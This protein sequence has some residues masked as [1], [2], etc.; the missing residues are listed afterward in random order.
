MSAI[1]GQPAPDFELPGSEGSMIKLSDYRG[2]KVILYFYPKDLTATCSTQACD[3]RDHHEQFTG[4][5]AIILGVSTDPLQRHSKFIEKYGLPFQLLADEEHTVSEA[6]GVWQQKQMYGKQYMGI[7]RSTF[8]I[9]EEGILV[10][11][12]RKVKVKGHIESVLQ[13]ISE[14]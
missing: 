1:I 11:E 5:G 6:Y 7:V 10:Q 9:D 4:Q 12:W 2:S 14:S 8:L 13:H 3:F